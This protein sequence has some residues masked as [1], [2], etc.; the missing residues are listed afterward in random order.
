MRPVSYLPTSSPPGPSVDDPD[1]IC[2]VRSVHEPERIVRRAVSRDLRH[3][4]ALHRRALPDGLPAQLGSRF[5]AR[6]HRA[7]LDSPHGVALVA[8]EYPVHGRPRLVGFLVGAVDQGAFRRELL[9]DHRGGLFA[10]GVLGLLPRPHLL[11]RVLGRRT[12]AGARGGCPPARVADLTAVA[13]AAD[14]RRAGV[15]QELVE[16]F[17]RDCAAA[18]SDWVELSAP[19]S[20]SA[21]PGFCARTGWIA[22]DDEPDRDGAPARR[23]GR[24]A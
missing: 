17:L 15:G 6:W 21:A 23:F 11:G 19:E 7:F 12:R 16:A 24:L 10:R 13:V 3:S 18:G 20:S 4:A 1:W 8:I 22:L 2:P 14:A 9:T 5:L